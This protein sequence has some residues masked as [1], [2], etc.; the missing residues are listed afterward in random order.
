MKITVL[1]DKDKFAD[2]RLAK[3]LSERAGVPFERGAGWMQVDADEACHV[4]PFPRG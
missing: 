4:W 1:A 2:A 3:A